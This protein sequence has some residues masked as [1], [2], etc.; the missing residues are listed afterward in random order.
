LDWIEPEESIDSVGGLY[1]L[2]DWL[3]KRKDAF[4]QEAQEYG[5]PKN[6]KGILLIGIQGAGKSVMC[7]AISKFWNLPLLKLDMGK[8]F[9]GIV[10]SS[11]ENIRNAIKIAESIAPTLVWTDEIDKGMAGSA[12][13]NN[14]DGGTAARVFGSLISWMQEKDKPVYIVATANDVSQLPPELLRKG[15]FDEIF[16]VDLPSEEERKEIIKIHL[17]KRK[18]NFNDFDINQISKESDGFTGAEIE[19]CIISAMY[20]S[21]NDGK[22]EPTSNDIINSI[23]ET[24]PLSITMSEHIE[25]LRNWAKNRARNASNKE[26]IDYNDHGEFHVERNINPDEEL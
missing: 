4:S 8:I 5:L 2:K 9:S 20:E 18:R 23:R 3:M 17:S 25:G 22:R 19:S 24:I 15:R 26:K 10:G 1:G 16:F 21:F 11:E 13:S 6:P 7:K 14:T 12:S